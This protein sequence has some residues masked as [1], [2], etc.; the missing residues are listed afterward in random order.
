MSSTLMSTVGKPAMTPLSRASWMPLSTEGMNSLGIDAAHDLVLELV[1][2]AGGQ[3]L[4]VDDAVAVLAVAAGLAHELA[5][6]A[7]DGLAGGLAVGDLGLAHVRL[8]LELAQQAV[9]DDLEV[10]LAHAGDDG[11]AGLG[12]GVHLEG[13]V[14]L[15]ELHEADLEL[16]LLVL[17]LG[18]DGDVDDGLGEDHRLEDDRGVLVAQGVAGRGVLEADDGHD[19]ARGARVAVDAVVGVHLEDAADTLAVALGAVERVG[20]GLELARSRCAGRS[21]CR[22][23]GRS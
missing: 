19:V 15:G 12:V 20:A 23:R 22:R 6:D 16:G 21:A 2:G 17:A 14:L 10:Q 4:H 13:R 5:L 11:L 18:L 1:A 7:A 8:D 9:D 3:G